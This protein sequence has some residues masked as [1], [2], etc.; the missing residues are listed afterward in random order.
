VLAKLREQ[1]A[2]VQMSPSGVL[3][4][5]AGLLLDCKSLLQVLGR[6]VE[7]VHRFEKAAEVIIRHGPQHAPSLGVHMRVRRI[8]ERKSSAKD[9]SLA[10]LEIALS[11]RSLSRQKWLVHNRAEISLSIGF[12]RAVLCAPKHLKD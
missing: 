12:S 3:R 10:M 4:L 8:R 6:R 9:V 5:R 7:L 2:Q 11:H 1:R